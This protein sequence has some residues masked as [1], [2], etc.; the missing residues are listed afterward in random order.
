MGPIE[1]VFLVVVAIF[2]VIAL[3]RGY[4]K[5]L[6]VTTMLLIALF[7]LEFLNERYQALVD[8]ALGIATARTRYL[9]PWLFVLFLLVIAFISYQGRHARISRHEATRDFFDV[10]V[11]L[12]N[13]YLL[14]GSIWYYL[15]QAGWPGLPVV[16]TYTT[17]IP[18]HGAAFTTGRLQLAVLHWPGSHPANRKSL[19][20]SDRPENESASFARRAPKHDD[21]PWVSLLERPRETPVHF[22]LVGIGGTG[23]SAIA[24][25]LL[26]RGYTVSGSD[27]RPNEMT[28]AFAAARG[29]RCSAAIAQRTSRAPTSS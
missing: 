19:E 15:Q 2:V 3:V 13:G 14:A 27:Q 22:H 8:K 25:F 1:T 4:N 5:E 12:L 17:R 24:G 9:R 28:E 10:G 18:G 16:Q 7:V 23:L 29:R 26:E 11:G 20:M 21:P 6:G